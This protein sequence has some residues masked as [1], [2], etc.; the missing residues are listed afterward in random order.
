M[1]LPVVIWRG[2]APDSAEGLY[3]VAESLTQ[4]CARPEGPADQSTVFECELFDMRVG[5]RGRKRRRIIAAQAT[6]VGRV[7]SCCLSFAAVAFHTCTGGCAKRSRCDSQLLGSKASAGTLKAR[8]G[9]AQSKLRTQA[10]GEC[11]TLNEL[12]ADAGTARPI[13]KFCKHLP[14]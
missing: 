10:P 8:P 9:K 3:A 13:P 12:L 14:A 11:Q 6:E 1:A 4:P 5:D 2:G 7:S